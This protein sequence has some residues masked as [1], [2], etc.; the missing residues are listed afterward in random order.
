MEDIVEKIED[1]YGVADRIWVMD[2]GMIS[3]HNLEF[4]RQKQRR[5]IV[6]TPKSQLRRFEAEII[7]QGWT[8]VHAGLEVKLCAAPDGPEE[9]R[10]SPRSSAA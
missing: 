7:G 2:R 5:Y 4:L 8:E 1:Q 6:G 3:E 10:P 9:R